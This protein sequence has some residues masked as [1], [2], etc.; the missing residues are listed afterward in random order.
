MISSGLLMQ[1]DEGTLIL[2]VDLI[3]RFYRRLPTRASFPVILVG[4]RRLDASKADEGT[5]LLVVDLIRRFYR[6]LP[7][8]ASFPVILV[9]A[10]RLDASKGCWPPAAAASANP[11]VSAAEAPE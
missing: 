1:A 2:V 6:R 9:G 3:R 8:R 11:T 5:L 10:R 7:T 4:A